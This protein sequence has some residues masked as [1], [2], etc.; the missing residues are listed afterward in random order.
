[1]SKGSDYVK[2]RLPAALLAE[3]EASLESNNARTREEMMTLS[4]WIR[5]AIQH[6]LRKCHWRRWKAARRQ[7]LASAAQIAEEGGV[8]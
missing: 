4:D 5:R 6:R 8:K 2:V 1:M 7:R 3:V